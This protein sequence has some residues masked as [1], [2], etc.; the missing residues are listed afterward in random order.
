MG[1]AAGL[2]SAHAIDLVRASA[3]HFLYVSIA[4][5]P[6]AKFFKAF[7]CHFKTPFYVE[8]LRKELRRKKGLPWGWGPLNAVDEGSV[9]IWS[10]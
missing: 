5:H 3:N 4:E 6:L 8:P 2:D 10:G 9:S 7:R 1:G